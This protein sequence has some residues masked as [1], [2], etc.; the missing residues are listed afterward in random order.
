[1]DFFAEITLPQIVLFPIAGLGV[2]VGIRAWQDRQV[3]EL[4]DQPQGTAFKP[5]PKPKESAVMRTDEYP[6]AALSMIFLAISV[7][8]FAI[9]FMLAGN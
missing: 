7:A 3:R 1:M 9:A 6:I 5:K 8:G 2:G 4:K